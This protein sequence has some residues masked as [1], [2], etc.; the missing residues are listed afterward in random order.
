LINQ[1]CTSF[2][3]DAA[4]WGKKTKVMSEVRE[5]QIEEPQDMQ[6]GVLSHIKDIPSVIKCGNGHFPAMCGIL[7]IRRLIAASGETSA[8]TL[9]M[10]P[11]PAYG[12]QRL[13]NCRSHWYCGWKLALIPGKNPHSK[14]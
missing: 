8:N 13:P 3:V 10:N 12:V 6:V 5:A 2:L 7:V 9:K 1:F 14:S 11:M 4:L